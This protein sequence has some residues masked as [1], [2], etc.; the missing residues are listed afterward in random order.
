MPRFRPTTIILALLLIGSAA[1][2]GADGAHDGDVVVT[3]A[4]T[5]AAGV[6]PYEMKELWRRGG[7]DDEELFFGTIAEFLHDD[8]G[9]VYLL[10][11]QIAEVQ[12][13]D[14]RGEWLRTIGRQ[15]EGPGE[16][17][18]GADMFWGFGG[19]IGVVQAWP[20][21]IVMLTPDGA[22]GTSFSLPYRDGG[23]W[24]AVSRAAGHGDG[25]I[26]AGTA[27]TREEGQQIQFT[28]L[29]AYDE[30]GEELAT[31]CETSRETQFG[32]YEFIEE[33]YTDFQRR[34]DVAPDGRVA[35]S[36]SFDE[37]RIHV[38]NP[39]GGVNMV[40]ERPDYPAVARSAEEM[41]LFQTMYDS[42]TRWNRGSTF[43][44][45]PN[46][47]AVERVIFRPDGSLWV[48]SGAGRWRPDDGVFAC[49]DVYD[50][51][52]VF[53]KRIDLVADADPV[54]DG[55]YLVGDRA[56]V[57]TDLLNAVMANMGGGGDGADAADAEPLAVVSYDIAAT[58]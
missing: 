9:N 15:G 12:V 29:K 46:H 18:N 14:P 43:R 31:Y 55:L 57:V 53:Q 41:E 19:Q 21:K 20:G 56:Y 52:G 35:A 42:F 48:Q 6:H 11:G 8:E 34:W 33:E 54:D 28:Y 5:P 13:L 16:F 49:F 30:S 24:Q 45:N 22:P 26:M 2:F 36:L 40:I 1:A 10:D 39:D 17:Q 3:N 38:W 4:E 23:G 7:E 50:R 27:W 32:D 37:Y 51:R 44:V 47:Q 25:V 58:P